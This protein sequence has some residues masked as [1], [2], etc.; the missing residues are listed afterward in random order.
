MP[1]YLEHTMQAFARNQDQMRKYFADA[2]NGMFPFGALEEMGKQNM[3]MFERALSLNP[4]LADGRYSLMLTHAGR[5]REGIDA[6]RKIMRLDPFHPPIYFGWLANAQYLLGQYEAAYRSLSTVASQQQQHRPTQ[7]WFAAV[8]GQLGRDHE[9]KTAGAR[10]LSI[11]PD[12]T[13]ERWLKLLQLSRPEDSVRLAEGM[14]KA[15]LPE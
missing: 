3:A 1:R 15:G 4:N 14:R 10:V 8:A 5:A 12:F 13:I 11:E 9:A 2:M 7:V 6:M